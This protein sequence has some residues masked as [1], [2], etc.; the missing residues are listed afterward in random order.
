MRSVIAVVL[1]ATAS[2]FAPGA[3]H[4][5]PVKLPLRR[6]CSICG[7]AARLGVLRWKP[8]AAA[9]HSKLAGDDAQGRA[10]TRPAPLLPSAVLAWACLPLAAVA[11]GGGDEDKRVLY[12]TIYTLAHLPVIVPFLLFWKVDA[13]TKIKGAAIASP[14]FVGWIALLGGW[15]RF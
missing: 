5:S 10:T 14:F 2:A 7:S 6:G 4:S 15:L 8:A 3:L 12:T 11:E 1:L 9:T 13:Q